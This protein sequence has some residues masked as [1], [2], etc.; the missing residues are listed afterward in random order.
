MFYVEGLLLGLPEGCKEFGLPEMEAIVITKDPFVAAS[1]FVKT[2]Y[3]I[4]GYRAIALVTKNTRL[5]GPDV[6]VFTELF[7]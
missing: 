2:L 4:W 6:A 5:T 3:N 1:T 7:V